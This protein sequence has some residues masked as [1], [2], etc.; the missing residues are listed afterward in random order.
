MGDSVE[1][2]T[3]TSSDEDSPSEVKNSLNKKTEV[4]EEKTHANGKQ[5]AR[6]SIQ[7]NMGLLTSSLKQKS[8]AAS[9]RSLVSNLN[10]ANSNASMMGVTS[11]GK[12]SVIVPPVKK[13]KSDPSKRN[14]LKSNANIPTLATKSKNNA[15]LVSE[16]NALST[17]TTAV[18]D[19][20]HITVT[21]V[22]KSSAHSYLNSKPFQTARKSFSSQ[23]V[24]KLPLDIQVTPANSNALN[25]KTIQPVN[26]LKKKSSQKENSNGRNFLAKEMSISSQLT[27]QMPSSIQITSTKSNTSSSSCQLSDKIISDF[28][29]NT[30]TVM[31]NVVLQLV[32]G[33]TSSST[34]LLQNNGSIGENSVTTENVNKKA[35]KSFKTSNINIPA[36]LLSSLGKSGIS[37]SN[38]NTSDSTKSHESTSGVDK[39]KNENINE[40]LGTKLLN[41]I[42]PDVSITEVKS[43]KPFVTEPTHNKIESIGKNKSICSIDD[44]NTKIK[45]KNVSKSNEEEVAKNIFVGSSDRKSVISK[46]NIPDKKI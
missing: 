20:P 1:V 8:E 38:I 45:S 6:K 23:L 42:I 37:I 24:N 7:S 27:N 40:D 2:I 13:L 21:S 28:N 32:H 25:K 43:K 29:K 35:R 36:S 5:T 22:S 41:K 10:K 4:K 39:K 9:S 18:K 30:T 11:T 46:I 14:S 12:K 19:L 15:A 44:H 26:A 33:S 31:E 34:E 16:K 3:L 17:V